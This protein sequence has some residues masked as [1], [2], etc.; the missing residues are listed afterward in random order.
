MSSAR[1]T[2][3]VTASARPPRASMAAAVSR[4]LAAVRPAATTAAPASASAR[5]MPLPTPWPAPVTSA[6][7]PARLA[8]GLHL[9]LRRRHAR[10]PVR[11]ELGRRAEWLDLLVQ[12]LVHRLADAPLP[13]LLQVLVAVQRAAG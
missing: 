13:V 6:I 7:L 8:T 2:S 10:Q 9:L 5:A 11:G 3:H 12:P 4:T 1:N